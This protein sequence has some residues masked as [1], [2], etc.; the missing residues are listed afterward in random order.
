MVT[1][2]ELSY[3][4]GLIGAWPGMHIS[5]KSCALPDF[6]SPCPVG[7]PLGKQV[8]NDFRSKLSTSSYT[9][10]TDPEYG[11]PI[12]S[13]RLR[14]V[15][16]P[17]NPVHHM[18]GGIVSNSTSNSSGGGTN[19]TSL[20]ADHLAT[21]FSTGPVAVATML[22]SSNGSAASN[23]SSNSPF[24]IFLR[25]RR[26]GTPGDDHVCWSERPRW[27]RTWFL[28]RPHLAGWSNMLQMLVPEYMS[29]VPAYTSFRGT[30][31]LYVSDRSRSRIS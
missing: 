27:I 6:I 5:I 17:R 24:S 3:G 19:G 9:F 8:W 7:T 28:T 2:A 31:P 13:H 26:R 23:T 20:T 18:D 11:G 10:N 12:T 30:L 21:S 14:S 22:S 15:E 1:A 16:E 25:R 4:G 29:L